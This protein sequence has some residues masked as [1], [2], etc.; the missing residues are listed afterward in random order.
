MLS[1][2]EAVVPEQDLVTYRFRPQVQMRSE[3]VPPRTLPTQILD[4][5]IPKVSMAAEP[6]KEEL[7]SVDHQSTSP[8]R[9]GHQIFAASRVLQVKTTD[10]TKYVVESGDQ[11]DKISKK[12]YGTY[13][14]YKEILGANPGLDPRSL[15]PGMV[16]KIPQAPEGLPVNSLAYVKEPREK[17]NE[18]LIQ[19]GDTLGEIAQRKLGS[20]KWVPQILE[21]NS[22]LNPSRLKVGQKIKLPD[23]SRASR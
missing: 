18:Y 14:R 19:S 23:V 15:R 17:S 12:F 11:L 5:N 21:L 2:D 9:G 1:N 13:Q 7:A 3:W 22:G 16:I 4:Q 8:E 20:T 6:K 10:H